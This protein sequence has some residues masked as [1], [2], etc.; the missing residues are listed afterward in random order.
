MPANDDARILIVALCIVAVLNLVV[1][2]WW[3]READRLRDLAIRGNAA[4][5]NGVRPPRRTDL[6]P[7]LRDNTLEARTYRVV[8][9][10][11]GLR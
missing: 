7:E 8:R 9:K 4:P 3:K 10:L 5:N 6:F 2:L 1:A 11:L